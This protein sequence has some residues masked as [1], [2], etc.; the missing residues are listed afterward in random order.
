MGLGKS[1]IAWCPSCKK[2]RTVQHSPG[3]GWYGRLCNH[4]TETPKAP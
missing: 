4:K 2:F 3:Y 1:A